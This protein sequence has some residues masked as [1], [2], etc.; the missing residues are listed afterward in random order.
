M[1]IGQAIANEHRYNICNIVMDSQ[2]ELNITDLRKVVNI[3]YENLRNNLKVLVDAVLIHLDKQHH[4]S[5]KPV[6]VKKTET[7]EGLRSD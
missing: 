7:L 6:L 5:H 1:K 2:K 3:S 4:A